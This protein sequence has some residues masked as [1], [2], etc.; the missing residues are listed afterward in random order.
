MGNIVDSFVF[1]PPQYSN[2]TRPEIPDD[3]IFIESTSGYR[4]PCLYK[5]T[6]SKYTIIYSHG[7]AEDLYM[8]DTWIRY[9]STI[10]PIS[11]IAYDYTG[12]GASYSPIDKQIYPSEYNCYEDIYSIYRFLINNGVDSNNIIAFG[13]S[14]G[15]GPSCYLAQHHQLGGLILQSAYMSID[16]VKIPFSVPGLERF[17]NL[18]RISTIKCKVVFIHGKEDQYIPLIHSQTLSN[19]CGQR[20][21]YWWVDGGGHNDLEY[22]S[23]EEYINNMRLFLDSVFN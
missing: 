17:N 13:R 22:V 14:L 3:W 1:L 10:T 20:N 11:I 4:I 15:T 23:G 5:K 21:V 7:N 8:L 2:N 12:Y 16:K 9:L 6:S 18:N 19:K